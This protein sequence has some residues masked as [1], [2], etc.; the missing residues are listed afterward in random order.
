MKIEEYAR[1]KSRIDALR[2]Q[3]A[4][5]EGALEQAVRKLEKELGVPEEEAADCIEEMRRQ[6]AKQRHAV[7]Q[8]LAEFERKWRERLE[9]VG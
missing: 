7:D 3:K 2:Q 8:M 1:L 5:A 6:V 9:E 4:R